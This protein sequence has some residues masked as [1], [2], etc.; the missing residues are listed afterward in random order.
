MPLNFLSTPRMSSSTIV[1]TALNS[2]GVL[3][4]EAPEAV[5]F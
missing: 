5:L 3:K 2:L 1:K 4:C